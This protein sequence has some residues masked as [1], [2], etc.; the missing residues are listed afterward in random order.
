MFPGMRTI[1]PN[2]F[3][4]AN[5]GFAQALY[6]DYL[7][8]PASVAPEWRELFESGRVGEP[9]DNGTGEAAG[10]QGV[11]SATESVLPPGRPAVLPSSEAPRGQAIP[12][13][14]PAARLV[15]N[16]TESLSVPTATS[17]REI[18]VGALEQAR[19]D[20]NTALRGAG[21]KEKA[22]FTHFIA[23]A[24]VQAIRRHPVMGH[25]LAMREGAPHRVVP[26][27]VHLG[28]AVDV[29]RKDG[30]RGL[31]VPVVKHADRMSY[32]EFHAEYDRLVEKARTNRLLPDD[33]AGGTVTLTNPGGIGTVASVPRLMAG[34]GSIIAVGAI[35]YPAAF[36]DPTPEQVARLGLSRV[37]TI[38]STY[39]HRVIQGAESGE[40]LRTVEQ[41][42]AGQDRFYEG[43]FE[44][45]GVARKTTGRQ[46]V[47]AA[48]EPA[49]GRQDGTTAVEIAQKV[50]TLPSSRPAVLPSS[51]DDVAAG[52]A[53]V[54][55]YRTHGH[56]AARLDPLG[57]P[58]PGDPALDPARQGLTEE[59]MRAI[60]ANVLRVAVP[61]ETLADAL[62][63]LQATYC[64][65]IAYEVEH[66][67]DH[68]QRAWLRQIIESGAHRT[69]LEPEERLALLDRLIAVEAFE[70][71]L[72]KS[73]LGQ[74]R[75]S[76]E[77]LDL[78][79]PMLDLLFDLAAEHGARE[80]VMGM[81]HRGRLNVLVHNVG[82]P[83]AA[84]FAEFEGGKQEAEHPETGHDGTGDV[85]YH[86]GAEGAYLTRSGRSITVALINNP[87]HLESVDPI[88]NGNTRAR[89][90]Q[91]R[92]RD[93]HHDPSVAM[94]V[95]IHGDA[96][97]A[98]QGIVAETLN[99]N[100]LRGYR[101]G[102][103][104]HLIANNQV[105][106]TTDMND[107]RSTQHASD[108][109]KGFDIPIIHVNADDAEGCL[110]A[111]RLAVMYR[112]QF[113]RDILI[114]L[115]GYR[116]W[117]HN[118]ADEPAYTQPLMYERIRNHPS[119]RARYAQRLVEE[120]LLAPEAAE[121]RYQAAYQRLIDIQQG[122]RASAAQ[123]APPQ[124]VP[125]RLVASETVDTAVPADRLR[126]L[127]ES[128]LAVPEGFTV[129]PK[130]KRQLERRRA[131]LGETGGID[132]GHAEALA[133]ASLLTEGVPVRLTGQD[134]ERGTFSQRHLV[135]HD[136]GT[137]RSYAPIQRLPT[138]LAACEIYNSPLSELATL[139]F[140]YGYATAASESLVLWE[141]QYGDFINGAQVVVDQFIAAGLAKW[142]VTNRLTLLLPHGYEGGGPEHSSARIER[143]LQLAAEGNFRIANCTTPA[144]Y[145]H[146]LRRQARRAR[147]RP[148]VIFSPKSLLRL[149]QAAS[150]LE[151]LT[152]GTFQPVLDDPDPR[153][154]ADRRAVRRVILCS[155]KI[156]YDLLAAADKAESR[157]AIVR[158]EGLH[159][160]LEDP[161]RRVLAGYP[162]ANDFLWVQEEPRN[163]GAWFYVAPRIAPLL[164]SGARFRYVGRP[165][166]A[167]PAEGY[168]EAHNAEQ[169]RI[170]AEALEARG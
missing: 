137:G 79:V 44:S 62:P 64:G 63:G 116:R 24:L 158:M 105:G 155:G 39:D 61:G 50:A 75:F 168:P 108:L 120:G 90:T 30:S 127:N 34:Q 146:L 56:L 66:V 149:P 72:H 92:A 142:G 118:E 93:L 25:T 8:D 138:A 141:A 157:P 85:K 151:D 36:L 58:P 10:R 31:V 22:S 67:S 140:E 68:E 115:V 13:K 139:G 133:I 27:G 166:R 11:K 164:P 124:P 3:E 165:E 55:A 114:D 80:I 128:L 119:A 123:A 76:I 107:A 111:V 6:E 170:V 130:L 126:A 101:V 84:I 167:S 132:W 100:A 1:D 17:Y 40:F 136:A 97:F 57:T 78:M 59:R 28:L 47:T 53:L 51:L 12:L 35:R 154:Q 26:D 73:Y 96:A 2:V 129:N 156:Y 147:V 159:T 15:Q 71:F 152:Q 41:L 70:Q 45:F 43:I 87:S 145:F 48:A 162:D 94:P 74:K 91:R 7:K 144:Q 77:G 83:Y 109:A 54:D 82:R 81:A 134:T 106:F 23:W 117:G 160:F 19:A 18:A 86:L 112:Q 163:M 69:A 98:G 49:A 131:A 122:Y 21:R 46:G 161:L 37:M 103:T 32:A 89:Q 20:F 121:P 153:I 16:M 148:L 52:M 150:R 113:H 9:P 99:L 143:F 135:L 95:L 65:T 4:T 102:G 104:I 169:D 38:S 5:A 60:P 14:G 33:F 88:V 125:A 110:A 29:E 42:L